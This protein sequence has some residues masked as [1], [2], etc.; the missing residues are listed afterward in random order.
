MEFTRRDL[1]KLALAAV[2]AVKC[3]GAPNSKIGGVQIGVQS[4]S[5]R[6]MNNLDDVLNA[7][8][9]CGL[10][11]VELMSNHVEAGAGAPEQPRFGGGARRPPTAPGT[12]P[13]PP[14]PEQIAAMRAAANTPEVQ[15]AREDLKKWRM[16]STA[17]T[18]KPVRQKFADAGI[19]LHLLCY[20]M[21]ERTEDD[22]IEYAFQMA[23]ALGVHAITTSTQVSVSK[24]I[25]P[26]AEKHK[27]I[28]AYHGHDNVSNP[29]EFATLESFATALSYSKWAAVNLDIG[30]FTAANFEPIGY[31]KENHKRIVNLHLKD[32][33][34]NHGP[35]T[36]WGQGDTPIKEVLLLMKKEKYPF[37]ANIEY[38]YRGESDPVTEVTKCYQF[39]K[40]ALA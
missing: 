5:F 35:N 22:E 25:A 24:R 28:V 30:H 21:N 34:K 11:E 1:G 18:F 39:C 10:S 19:D 32:R 27:M 38:E 12:P 16:S 4:Y 14:T 17:D 9:T 37:P 40:D 8:S 29:N 15:K 13:T 20:N 23:K 36:V 2:P 6:N 31:I 3:F 33:K 7:I 26:F